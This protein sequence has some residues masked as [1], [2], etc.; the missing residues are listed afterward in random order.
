MFIPQNTLTSI[1][2]IEIKYKCLGMIFK[3]FKPYK[4][5]NLSMETVMRYHH[6]TV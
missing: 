6:F 3:V 5:K 1:R 4:G 2:M